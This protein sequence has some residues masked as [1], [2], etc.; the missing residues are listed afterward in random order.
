M[1][2][3]ETL[4]Q[5]IGLTDI[6]EVAFPLKGGRDEGKKVFTCVYIREKREERRPID[7]WER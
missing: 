6:S 3:Y 2:T 1:Q 4:A 5:T 7:I